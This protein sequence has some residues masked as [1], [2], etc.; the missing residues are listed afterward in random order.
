MNKLLVMAGCAAMALTGC[1]NSAE[2]S[3]KSWDDLAVENAH[4]QIGLQIAAIEQDT[5]ATVLN[6]VTTARNR[7]STKYCGYADWRSGFFPGTVWYLYELTGDT[8]LVPLAEKYTEAIAEAQ[9]LTWHHDIGFIINC[10]YGNGRRLADKPEYNDVLVQAAKSL[11]TRFREA[12]GLIQSWNVKENSWQSKRGWECPVIID[13]MMNLELL[14]EATKLTGDSTYYNMAVKHADRTMKE[15]FRPDGSCYH[16]VDYDLK[17]GSVR[18]RQ[19]AQGYADESAWARGQAW[20]IYGYTMCYRETGD[21]R[22]LDQAVR[23]FEFMK[24]HPNM[25]EDLVPYWDMNAPDIPNEPRDASSAAVIASALYELSTYP[26]ENPGEYKEYADKIMESLA[27]DKYTAKPG[28]NGRFI[29]MHSVGSIPHN[30]EI[31][32][33]LNYADYYFLEGLKRKRDLEQKN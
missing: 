14:F 15:H 10:S 31:D 1:D 7:M 5:S 32:V 28:E 4:E 26:V 18:H 23:T 17:D 29:L 3:A 27:S 25:P 21:S 33:P 13:N 16:V 20:A 12:P 2:R 9:N 8:A 24:N 19:T 11:A 6:P 30:N 22:Y